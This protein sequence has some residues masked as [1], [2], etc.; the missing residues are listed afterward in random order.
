MIQETYNHYII[1]LVKE[2]L[3]LPLDQVSSKYETLTFPSSLPTGNYIQ[4]HGIKIFKGDRLY[5]STLLIHDEGGTTTIHKTCYLIFEDQLIICIGNYIMCLSIPDLNLK[6]SVKADT[7]SCFQLFMRDEFFIVHGE[8]SISKL[9]YSGEL[10][11][12]FSGRD[13]F[14][15][16]G[17]EKESEVTLFED[18]IQ[19]IDFEKNLYKIDYNG[20]LLEDLPYK[21]HA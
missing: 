19:L 21:T 11:W 7:V 10:V 1:Q 9:S 14:V 2:N 8:L 20:K 17:E 18:Y 15:L 12:Q 6:W 3:D 13:I 4:K 5:K 16:P